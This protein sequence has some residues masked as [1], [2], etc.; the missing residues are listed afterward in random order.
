MNLELLSRPHVKP[1][2]AVGHTAAGLCW[3]LSISGRP[4]SLLATR[5]LLYHTL[6]TVFIIEHE[7]DTL[8]ESVGAKESVAVRSNRTLC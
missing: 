5:F 4:R 8:L 7:V 1:A 3:R 2:M 6:S